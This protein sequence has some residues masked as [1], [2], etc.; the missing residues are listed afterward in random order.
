M[1][2]YKEEIFG[3]VLL[4]IEAQ[5]LDEAIELV[6]NNAWGNGAVIFTESGSVANKFQHEIEAGQ[7]GINVPIPVPLPMFS[8]TGNKRS[9]AGTGLANFYG[10]DG[11]RFYTQWK[12]VT[13][14]WR[15]ETATPSQK[16]TTLG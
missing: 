11:L 13:S 4:C 9:V 12:T 14:L 10:K 2:A 6:N 8:F 3:P 15:S 1:E 5:T 7:V 16:L